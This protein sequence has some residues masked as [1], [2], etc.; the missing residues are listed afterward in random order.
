MLRTIILPKKQKQ[1]NKHLK[2]K[3]SGRYSET[4]QQFS[5]ETDFGNGKIGKFWQKVMSGKLILAGTEPFLKEDSLQI[6]TCN[7]G[8]KSSISIL[9]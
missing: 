7:N 3:T 5:S 6:V 8:K 4:I 2:P 1:T 9:A